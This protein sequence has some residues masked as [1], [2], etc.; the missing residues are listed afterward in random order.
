MR[1]GFLSKRIVLLQAL[2]SAP[3]DIRRILKGTDGTAAQ[4]VP[5]GG[6]HSLLSFVAYCTTFEQ[7]YLRQLQQLAAM[8]AD[9]EKRPTFSPVSPTELPLADTLDEQL[10]L[11]IQARQ[12]TIDFLKQLRPGQWQRQV[13]VQQNDVTLR[14]LVQFLVDFDTQHLN[15]LIAL[16]Q[17]LK[18]R[19][20]QQAQPAIRLTSE[21]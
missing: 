15:Q 6:T 21:Q 18:L 19:P 4:R 5:A 10:A 16:Q 7:Q 3:N 9:P 20:N 8:P 11:F 17:Q 1:Q 2:M 13:R 12:E 14:Y